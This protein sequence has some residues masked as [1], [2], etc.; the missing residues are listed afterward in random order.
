MYC[1]ASQI[2]M[3]QYQ[4]HRVYRTLPSLVY[5]E[6]VC[7][8]DK[9]FVSPVPDIESFEGKDKGCLA[10]GGLLSGQQT[11]HVLKRANEVRK[12]FLN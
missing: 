8:K 9:V 12:R 3:V 4:G 2:V 6:W 5:L 1:V 11:S 7:T 10:V